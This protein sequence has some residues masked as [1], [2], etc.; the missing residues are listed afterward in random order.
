MEKTCNNCIKNP[1]P[2]VICD[3][4]EFVLFCDFCAD[5]M[6]DDMIAFQPIIL[7]ENFSDEKTTGI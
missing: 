5:C 3:D 2:E 6:V 7:N 1:S 4:G